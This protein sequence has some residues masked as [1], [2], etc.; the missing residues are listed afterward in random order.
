MRFFYSLLLH[1]A[2]PAILLRL[3]LRGENEPGYRKDIGERFGGAGVDNRPQ[4]ASAGT[5]PLPAIWIHAVSVGEVRAAMPLVGKLR[6]AYPGHPVVITCMTPT[7]RRTARDTFTSDVAVRYLPYDF[8]WAHR[9]FLVRWRPMMLIVMETEIWPNL[10][11][12]CASRDVPTFLVN[13]RLSEKSRAGYAKP[14]VRAIARGALQRFA[15]ILAQSEADAIR[16]QSLGARVV[17]VTG[18]LKFDLAVDPTAIARGEQWRLTV[19]ARPVVLVASTRDNEETPLLEAYKSVFS[20]TAAYPRPLLVVVP[21]HP[22]RFDDVCARIENAGLTVARRTTSEPSPMMDAWLGDSMGEMQAYYAMSDVPIIGGS[23]QPLGGQN[24]IEAAALGKAPIMGPST[25]NFAEAVRL[26]KEVDAMVQVRDAK[27]AMQEAAALLADRA[28]REAMG[29]R[30]KAF[31]A[32]HAGATE[33]TMAA[34]RAALRH[35]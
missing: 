5:H 13:A 22:S 17:S 3:W 35:S 34:I 6:H 20:D 25:F 2:I 4:V 28:R 33:R 26:A 7:G 8:G 19:G 1:L 10:L 12:A 11:A 31:A 14:L 9:R 32:A 27:A 29:A 18:N 16:L 30:A 23:F 15:V 21:R 24:L